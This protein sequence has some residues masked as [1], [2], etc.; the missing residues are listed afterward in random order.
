[1]TFPIAALFFV[2]LVALWPTATLVALV[3]RRFRW[4]LLNGL[5]PPFSLALA[6]L[7]PLLAHLP[8]FWEIAFAGVI[9][10]SW[11]VTWTLLPIIFGLTLPPH[12]LKT[13]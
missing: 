12:R 8:Q 9:V 11:I 10:I 6:A 2:S 3:S 13:P 7:D 4:T 1:V 5:A